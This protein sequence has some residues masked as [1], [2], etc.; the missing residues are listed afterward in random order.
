LPQARGN[1]DGQTRFLSSE[2]TAWSARLEGSPSQRGP[3]WGSI[4][5][6]LVRYRQGK[7]P[8]SNNLRKT[9]DPFVN[10]LLYFQN[11]HPKANPK[12]IRI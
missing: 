10:W 12:Y 2:P 3:G 7:P 8:G 4:A 6:R 1:P 5:E 9:K 11:F